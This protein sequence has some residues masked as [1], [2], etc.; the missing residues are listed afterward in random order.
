MNAKLFA[1]LFAV[2]V[3]A[4]L[5]FVSETV[6]AQSCAG[7]TVLNESSVDLNESAI[8]EAVTPWVNHGHQVYVFVTDAKVPSEGEWRATRDRVEIA[9]G[10]YDRSND[11]FSKKAVSVELTTDTSKPWGQDLA[12]GE[13]LFGTALDSDQAVQGIE[14]QMKNTVA[15]GDVNGAIVKAFNN[16]YTLAYPP[17]TATPLPRPTPVDVLMKF[18]ITKYFF[19]REEEMDLEPLMN[20]VLEYWIFHQY[21]EK[22]IYNN[23][24]EYIY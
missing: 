22:Y 21:N 23:I 15:S 20:I 10:I 16:A 11:S 2:L 3:L 14:G 18:I 5:P 1:R 19:C 7:L 4:F 13:V 6:H 12:F 24:Q 8:C 9:W 17:A